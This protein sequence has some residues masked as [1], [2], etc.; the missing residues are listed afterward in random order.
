M[1]KSEIIGVVLVR[2]EDV[3]VEQALRNVIDFCDR[4]IIADHQS[5]DRTTEIAS[6]LA[7]EFPEKIAL[8]RIAEAR[9]SH[10]LING[11]A[12]SQAWIFAV[13]GDEIY[14]PAGLR[15]LREELCAGKYDEWW[16]LFGNVL[17]CVAI[18]RAMGTATGHLAPPCRSMTKLFNFRL[19]ES[20]DGA[21]THVLAN[22]T[23][24]FKPGYD[25]TRRLSLHEQ[26]PWEDSH[27]RC[28]H[29]CFMRRS[30]IDAEGATARP[31]VSESLRRGP[32]EWLKKIGRRL[33]GRANCSDWKLEKYAR[34]PLVTVDVKAF[35]PKDQDGEAR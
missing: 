10:A 34:G 30:S 1:G 17:N 27:Y 35:F 24:R 18:D 16:L 21:Y 4:L 7:A 13:D 26:I 28:L 29:T 3:F 2:N 11:H 31:N 33:K 25:A 32:V 6:K 14:D 19:I 15:R 22:G 12:G 5:T 8:R 20:W 9:E 23:V